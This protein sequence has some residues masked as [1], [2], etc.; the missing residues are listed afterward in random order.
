MAFEMLTGRPVF[1]RPNAQSLLAAHVTQAPELVSQLRTAVPPG[2][3]TVVMRCLEKRAADRWQHAAELLPQL[4][5]LLT[6]STGG[7]MP[8]SAAYTVSTGTEA[9]LRRSQPARG[10]G[11]YV[12]ASIGVLGVV[13]MLVKQLGLP[14]W[15]FIGAVVLLVVGLPIML[16]TARHERQRAIARST[17]ALV[18]TPTGVRRLFTWQRAFASVDPT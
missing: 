17:N 16:I 11:T 14:T 18:I 9:A 12:L 5:F 13:W 8:T 1:V 7:T 4:D 15:V 6:P 10:L 3:N 2:L